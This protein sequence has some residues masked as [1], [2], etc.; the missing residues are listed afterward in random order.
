MTLRGFGP[1]AAG[2]ELDGPSDPL[3]LFGSPPLGNQQIDLAASSS[4]RVLDASQRFSYKTLSPE[5]RNAQQ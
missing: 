2:N 1:L 4:S 3:S 5:V